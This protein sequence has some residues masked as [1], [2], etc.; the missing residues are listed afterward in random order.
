M[1]TRRIRRLA[2]RRLRRI[3]MVVASIGLLGLGVGLA[4]PR[5]APM[6]AFLVVVAVVSLVG[7]TARAD[8][9]APSHS[10]SG[11]VRLP[12]TAAISASVESFRARIAGTAHALRRP[13]PR[14]LPGVPYVL[15]YGP[16]EFVRPVDVTTGADH[17]VR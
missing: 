8:T 3:L 13:A 4:L 12:T 1:E 16:D 5:S 2:Q 7:I 6:S 11:V 17:V 14:P 9:R 15:D 10:L